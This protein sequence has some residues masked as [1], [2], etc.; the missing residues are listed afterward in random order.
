MPPFGEDSAVCALAES[1]GLVLSR[2][3]GIEITDEA[4]IKAAGLMRQTPDYAAIRKALRDGAEVPGARAGGVEY[5][6]RRGN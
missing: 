2:R 1:L 3:D 6:L 4:A 5:V